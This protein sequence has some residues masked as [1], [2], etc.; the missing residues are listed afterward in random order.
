MG[1]RRYGP[2]SVPCK[3]GRAASV[4]DAVL[5]ADLH[6]TTWRGRHPDS[7]QDHGAPGPNYQVLANP[8]SNPQSGVT[9]CALKHL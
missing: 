2:N 5:I 8:R 7:G 3:F 9:A 6:V 1:T 4:K